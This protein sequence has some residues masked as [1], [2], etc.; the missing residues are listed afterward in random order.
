MKPSKICLKSISFLLTFLILMQGCV[1]YKKKPSTID[2]AV[3][4][5]TNVR[6]QTKDNKIIK[7]K[8][9][10]F[11]NGEYLGI[12]EYLKPYNE[13]STSGLVIRKKRMEMTKTLLKLNDVQEIKIKD[14]TW[15]TILPIAIPIIVVS[16]PIIFIALLMSP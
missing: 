8:R 5:N 4:A 13:I 16:I 2:E 14:K 12:K 11:K 1:I 6:I 15:S 3:Y 7:F 9:I 10:E